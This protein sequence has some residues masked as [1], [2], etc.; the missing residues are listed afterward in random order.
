MRYDIYGRSG[1]RFP[2]PCLVYDAG[3]VLL[4]PIQ[5]CDTDTGEVTR[6]LTGAD[7]RLQLGPDLRVATVTE[8][9]P[10]P[11]RVEPWTPAAVAPDTPVIV[12]G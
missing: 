3:G 9:H 4:T 2:S 8:Y 11:L 12:G 5:A 10:A 7:G 1:D 6:C